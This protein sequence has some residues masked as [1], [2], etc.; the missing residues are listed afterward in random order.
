MSF[1]IVREYRY[2]GLLVKNLCDDIW[3]IPMPKNA[4]GHLVL[5]VLPVRPLPQN[6]Y[7]KMCAKLC[8]YFYAKKKK[9][10]GPYVL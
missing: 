7:I 8:V 10:I 1:D 4:L 5:C 6:L 3:V 9:K 2:L